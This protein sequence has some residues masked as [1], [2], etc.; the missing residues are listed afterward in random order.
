ELILRGDQAIRDKAVKVD[1]NAESGWRATIAKDIRGAYSNQDVDNKVVDAAFMIA[2]ANGGD[3]LDRAVR[4]AT[5]GI[6]DFN[7]S[8]VPM[9][10]GYTSDGQGAAE[11]KFRQAIG[12]VTPESLADQAPGGFVQAGRAQMPLADFVKNLP[13]AQLV[14]AGQGLYNVRAGAGLVTNAAGKRITLQ[15]K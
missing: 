15:L 3:D 7:G 1:G 12:A 5:G 10:Y 9:P 4:L 14:H 13:N 11:K 8:K 2:A 6:I